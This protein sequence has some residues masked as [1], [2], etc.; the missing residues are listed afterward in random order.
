[1]VL[2]DVLNECLFRD[3]QSVSDV[4]HEFIVEQLALRERAVRLGWIA[5]RSLAAAIR[6]Q[7]RSLGRHERWLDEAMS[8]VLD[9]VAQTV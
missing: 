9:D 5:R 6:A 4:E 3:T 7:D 1:L 2:E 8:T